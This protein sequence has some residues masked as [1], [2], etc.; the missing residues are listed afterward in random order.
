MKFL[1]EHACAGLLLDPGLGKTSITMGAVTELKREGMFEKA[2]VIAPRRVCHEVWPNEARDWKQFNSLRVAV[3]HQSSEKKRMVELERDADFYVINPEG[4]PWL[5]RNSDMK[6]DTLVVDESSKFKN[7][8]TQRFK[9]LKPFLE[10]FRRRW[11]LTGS[12]M[13]NGY[14]DLFGQM[15]ILDLGASLG[16]YITHYRTKYFF[17]TGFGGYTWKL[18]KGA[19]KRITKVIKPYA[20]RLKAED[21]VKMPK[22][23]GVEPPHFVRVT[24]PPKARELYDEM[25]EEMLVTL[26]SGTEVKAL[27]AAAA[28]NKCSQIA[29]G[30]LYFDKWTGD[31]ENLIMT[32]GFATVHD[33]KT[34]AMNDL[35]E[36]ASGMPVIVAY[37]FQHDLARI[38]AALPKG[39]PHLGGGTTDKRAGEIIRRWNAKDIPVLPAHPAAMGHGLNLQH[40]GN[41]IIIYG[42]PW[43][44]E[45][46]DQFIRRIWRQ[47]SEFA[48]VFVHH[49]VAT[50]TV[51]E[52]KMRAL[53][54]KATNQEGFMSALRSYAKARRRG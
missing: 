15:Y 11:I 43:D 17:Q 7:P 24:L 20:I 21:Y 33:V 32:R 37:E 42:I 1:L 9:L 5:V 53:D 18:Q 12:P 39:T 36:E 13:P 25:E 8:Q 46:Y 49:L 51:D 30:G 28:S 54:R 41:Q 16:K 29:N 27:S 50:K 48:N 47:G 14:M 3:L 40:G 45:M 4:L 19:D 31:N 44:Y 35:I 26:E 2:L 23:I 38:L 10:G 6:F 52:A 34:E 22:R